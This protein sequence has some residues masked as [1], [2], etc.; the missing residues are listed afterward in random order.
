MKTYNNLC[1]DARN[2]LREYGA[3][4]PNLEARSL[5]AYAA[6]KSLDELVRDYMLYASDEIEQGVQ[7]LVNRRIHGEPLAY[8]LGSWEFFGLDMVVTPDVLIPRIDTEVLVQEAL[9]CLPDRTADVRILDLC[10]GSGCIGCALGVNLPH[11]KIVMGDASDKALRVARANVMKH[12]LGARTSCLQVNAL[13]LP[14]DNIGTFDII[15]SN[16]PYITSADVLTLDSSVKDYEPLMA[17]DGGEDGYM[18]Y[19]TIIRKW[20]RCLREGGHL[21]F[22]VGEE[23]AQHVAQLMKR[24]NFKDIRIIKDTGCT[25]RVVSGHL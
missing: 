12:N 5:V 24:A 19:R 18:F 11:A 2:A 10:C 22:E 17:L 16:P 4:N 20:K 13:S 6:E 8:I 1:I 14:I 7:A 15:V 9:D 23:Q 21:L 25:E 3:E